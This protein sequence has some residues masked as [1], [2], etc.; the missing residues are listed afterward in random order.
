M[1]G[2][3]KRILQTMHDQIVS[4]PVNVKMQK[5]Y[6]RDLHKEIWAHDGVKPDQTLYRWWWEFLRASQDFP[7]VRREL[8][9]DQAKSKAIK[10]IERQFGKLGDDFNEW[11]EQT[12]SHL[13][14]ERGVPLVTVLMPMPDNT[15]FKEL[16]GVVVM[17][18]LSINRQLIQEQLDYILDDYHPGNELKRHAAS[19]ATVSIFPRVT[20]PNT[21]YDVL[22]SLWRERQ[23]SLKNKD[24]RPW[25][26]IYC[27]ATQDLKLKQKLMP[28]KRQ[29][30][31][32]KDKSPDALK[33]DNSEKAAER[34]KYS[35]KAEVLYQQADELLRN[36]IQGDF[37]R[38]D[39]FQ[40]RKRGNRG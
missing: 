14:S 11:W 23:L 35:R 24:E 2:S 17:I 20:H 8:V 7:S 27:D 30:S 31:T 16:N 10:K 29:T 21:K 5:R 28:S 3:E 40:A 9:K 33:S 34:L 6:P 37:P 18:P 32:K 25:W 38:D 15:A 19:T 13:F 26:E 1:K 12:G 39:A 4:N 22:V 36:A